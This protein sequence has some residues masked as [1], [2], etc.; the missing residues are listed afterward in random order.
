MKNEVVEKRRGSDK[1]NR[2]SGGRGL[3]TSKSHHT[4][5]VVVKL[6]LEKCPRML[7]IHILP[8]FLIECHY[9]KWK[10]DIF[11]K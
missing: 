8:R 4:G 9:M 5:C 3:S 6:E 2:G 7:R 10:G 11:W 1:K